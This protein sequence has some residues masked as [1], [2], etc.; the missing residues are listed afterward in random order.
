[1][2]NTVLKSNA[3]KIRTIYDGKVLCG[4]AGRRGCLTL[5]E[6]FESKVQDT[7]ET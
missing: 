7:A 3:R 1:M 5:F 6:H 4:F 2:N